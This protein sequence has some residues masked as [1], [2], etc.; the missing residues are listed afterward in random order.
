[1]VGAVISRAEAQVI[2]LALIYA[3]LDQADRIETKH[4]QAGLALWEYADASARYIFTGL[5]KEQQQIVDYLQT[6]RT[7]TEIYKDL[8]K[9][10]RKA[11]SINADLD[12]LVKLRQ[13]VLATSSDGVQRYSQTTNT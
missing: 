10:N 7:K 1:L 13:I 2:R 12:T 6:P 4:L 9:S 11:D 8:F 3:M 5:G